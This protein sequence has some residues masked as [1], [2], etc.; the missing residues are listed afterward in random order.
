MDGLT[1]LR[2]LREFSRVPVV[3]LSAR[4]QERDKI[5][6]LDAGADDYITKPFGVGELAARMRTA[7]RHSVRMAAGAAA[8]TVRSGDLKIDLE[9]RTVW[10]GE[11]PVHLTPN[12]YRILA[13]LARH[14]GRVVT[15]AQLIRELWG[16][17]RTGVSH[18][19]RVYIHQLRHKIEPEPG[20]PRHLI[21]E[22]WV[23]YRLT[24][25]QNENA[26]ET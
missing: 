12:E 20:N 11:S 13:L 6:G 10:R 17:D 19:L 15:Q 22:P 7:L 16:N 25:E 9:A 18:Q 4:G 24:G 1:V 5:D 21:T 2:N 26:C 8:G 23:G 14:A 3:I